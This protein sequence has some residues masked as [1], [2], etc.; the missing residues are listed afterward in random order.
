[1]FGS[2]LLKEALFYFS[3]VRSYL[4]FCATRPRRGARE[5]RQGDGW[6]KERPQ[7]VLIWTNKAEKVGE[8]DGERTWG[9]VAATDGH[10]REGDEIGSRKSFPSSSISL[11]PPTLYVLS[12]PPPSY[13]CPS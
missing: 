3:I 8:E 1:M 4:R 13:F 9:Y 10:S 12:P 2:Q 7:R 6:G 5:R 11:S